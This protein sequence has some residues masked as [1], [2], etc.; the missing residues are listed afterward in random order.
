M[1]GNVLN[2]WRKEKFKIDKSFK[3]EYCNSVLL[4]FKGMKKKI[5]SSL[6]DTL[7]VTKNLYILYAIIQ[8]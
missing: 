5:E 2:I 6:D 7:V 8:K 4:L 3:N 1:W